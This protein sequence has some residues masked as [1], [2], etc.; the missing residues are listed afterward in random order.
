MRTAECDFLTTSSGAL[1]DRKAV[2]HSSAGNKV[3]LAIADGSRKRVAGFTTYAVGN[4]EEVVVCSLGI[5]D[6][7]SS[8]TPGAAYCLSQSSAGEITATRPTSGEIQMVGVARSA[9]TLDIA[10][11]V[12]AT[13][14][15]SVA[16]VMSADDKNRVD[17]Y[18]GSGASGR[19]IDVHF[20]PNAGTTNAPEE[21]YTNNA[22]YEIRQKILVDFSHLGA[23]SRAGDLHARAY[24]TGSSPNGDVRLY[25]A[26]D[27]VELGAVNFTE[28]SATTKSAT[29]SSIPASGVKLIECQIRRNSGQRLYVVCVDADFYATS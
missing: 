18:I 23:G 5:L 29:L 21:T 16:G 19:M 12:D 1:G 13:A 6:G 8:L 28:G 25:N 2:C 26:T 10:I 24:V 7:F 17:T 15:A 11:Q 3:E 20:I 9:T 4:N 22:N 14:T 27:N